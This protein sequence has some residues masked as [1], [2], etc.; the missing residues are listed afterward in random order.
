MCVGVCHL[1]CKGYNYCKQLTWMPMQETCGAY[2]HVHT[3]MYM[4]MH[5]RASVREYIFIG[6]G[7]YLNDMS[8]MCE[9]TQI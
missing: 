1:L 6:L 5:V 8:C 2:T 3:C 7:I 4:Y 9:Y